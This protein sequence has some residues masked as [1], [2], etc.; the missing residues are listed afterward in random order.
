MGVVY[1]AEDNK[2]CRQVALKFLPEDLAR[3]HNALERFQREARAAS[4]LNHPN[5]CT[6]HEI[7]EADGHDFIAMELLEGCTLRD[8]IADNPL[9][10]EELIELAAQI[11]DALD[12][13][14]TKGI[15]HRDIKPANIFITRRGHAKILDFGLA[16]LMP[17]EPAG[18]DTTTLTYDSLTSPGATVG[19]VAYMS[20]EQVRGEEL[21]PR[22]DLFSFGSVLY[23][24]ATGA[25]P[26]RGD[27]S[28]VVFDA[29]L[30][31]EPTEPVRLN[32]KLP[33]ELKR[34]IGKALQKDRNFRYQGA[35]EIK[36][37]LLH[38]RQNTSAGTQLTRGK[39]E[40]GFLARHRNL[41]AISA[42]V[43]VAAVI[44]FVFT[45]PRAQGL[46]VRDEILVADFVNN[47]SEEIF[48][49]NLKTAVAVKLG[50]SPFL[51]TVSEMRVNEILHLMQIPTKGKLV[52]AV[53]REACQR[54]NAKAVL[55]SS[56]AHLG[57]EYVITMEAL[58]CRTG[59]TLAREQV[60]ARDQD[61]V[62]EALGQATAKLRG[63]LGESV[64]SV[65]R[66]DTPLAAV[67][68]SSLEALKAFSL[69]LKEQ[70]STNFVDAVRL[71]E[72]AVELDPKF[73][74]A[75][76]RMGVCYWNM[77]ERDRAAAYF[78]KAFELRERA[79]EREKYAIMA[80]YY[81][82]VT[83]ELDKEITTCQL[84]KESYPRDFH[85]YN[86]L[87]LIYFDLGWP[88]KALP[89]FMKSMEISPRAVS[90]LNTENTLIIL[91]RY[92]EAAA[93]IEGNMKQGLPDVTGFPRAS[94]LYQLAFIRGDS[95]GM[96]QWVQ[97]ARGTPGEA[98][99][100]AQQAQVKAFGGEL[101]QART[102]YREAIRLA[103]VQSSDAR[104]NNWLENLALV[105]AE[106]GNAA[107]ARG[108]LH[109]I[110]NPSGL[111]AFVLAQVGDTAAAQSISGEIARRSRLGTRVQRIELP[112]IR[113]AVALQRGD[114]TN[115][116]DALQPAVDH[117]LSA[118]WQID[119]PYVGCPLVPYIRGYTHLRRGAGVEATADFQKILDHRGSFATSPLFP[120]AY[121][122]LARARALAGDTSGSRSAYERFFS[123]WKDADP[124]IPILNEAKAE[125]EK[126]K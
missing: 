34:I 70:T 88:D 109:E 38:A 39:Q 4:A 105:E 28:G 21:D 57:R 14:H 73:A 61:L 29:I 125:Y 33:P 54:L 53:A 5:I 47:T 17:A 126:L 110:Q 113:A 65:Q 108:I 86:S 62:L 44:L 69:G 46:T 15:L 43:F 19:T 9:P 123:I 58:D 10:A 64:K 26:F 22:S 11:V 52:G 13:A 66:F 94:R 104:A 25:M 102:Q 107:Q 122:G 93:F 85:P 103:R 84:Y 75:Y 100:V 79:S 121:V 119:F 114:A 78:S 1:R 2:L 8:R 42:L 20:P 74:L 6:V 55:N 60:Q 120:L 96:A 24:M 116:L 18:G 32:P 51:N 118:P 87:G 99:M 95:T 30:N 112:L 35:A 45:R 111:G 67:T 40:K 106:F 92:D 81:D 76:Q 115:A 56:I 68:T 63:S 3:D 48:D 77:R 83:G 98:T 82:T 12:A 124:D 91:G 23:E 31:R 97:K 89:E 27:T 71:Y 37:D 117:D 80:E 72:R 49:D 7:D 101:Q 36:A 41:A 90:V 59:E 16:K 50:E